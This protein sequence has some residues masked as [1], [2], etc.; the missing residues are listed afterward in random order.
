[1]KIALALGLA[2]TVAVLGVQISGSVTLVE[3][4]LTALHGALAV[5]WTRPAP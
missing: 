2:L 4:V 3:E 1:M 5:D